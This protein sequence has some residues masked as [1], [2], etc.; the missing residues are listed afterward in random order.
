VLGENGQA[1]G[2]AEEEAALARDWGAPRAL[3]QALRAQG[4]VLGGKPGLALLDEA[5]EVIQDSPALLERARSITELGAA[6]RR[7]NQ[8][9]K[10]RELLQKGLDL[11]NRCGARPL[12]ERALAELVATGA[13]PRR[14][15]VSGRDSLTPSEFRVAEL[16]SGGQTNREIAQRL[17]VTQKTVETHLGHVFRKLGLESRAQLALALEHSAQPT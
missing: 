15:S 8:R 1:S 5:A 3:A 12:Q 10:A 7:A 9:A 11:A 13:R 6:L 2:L 17:F 4:L 14:L 16:A